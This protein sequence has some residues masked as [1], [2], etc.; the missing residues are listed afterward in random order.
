MEI[1]PSKGL[2]GTLTVAAD[3][4]ISHRAVILGSIAKGK[5]I[6]RNFLNGEDCL[7]TVDCFR[8]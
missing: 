3:K 6:I 4:S 8:E 2:Q 5:T 1:N 7:S